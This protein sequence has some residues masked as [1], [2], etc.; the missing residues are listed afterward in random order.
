MVAAPK[1]DGNSL[2][3]TAA[4]CENQSVRSSTA[5]AFTKLCRPPPPQ[6]Q[7]IVGAWPAPIAVL[8]FVLYASFWNSVYEIVPPDF[9][10]LNRL[11]ASSRIF[12][13][14]WVDRNQ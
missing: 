9:D 13:W 1:D 5:P 3:F 4:F 11:T 14:G 7:M 6:P 2:L 10:A 12:C 8:I